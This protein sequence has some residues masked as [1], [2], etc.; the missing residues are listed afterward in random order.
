MDV[1]E[2]ISDPQ[3]DWIQQIFRI[4]ER[5]LKKRPRPRALKGFTD[6]SILTP[7]FGNP[8]TIILGPG[9]PAMAHRTDEF[10]YISKIEEAVDAYMEI[11][12]TWCDL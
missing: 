3:N 6:A 12:K 9:E 10:C 5:F 1:G 4:M 8:P 7:A 11:I 2:M